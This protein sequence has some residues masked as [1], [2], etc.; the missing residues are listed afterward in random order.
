MPQNEKLKGEA[1]AKE[2]K[3]CYSLSQCFLGWRV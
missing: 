2:L 3:K 1:E